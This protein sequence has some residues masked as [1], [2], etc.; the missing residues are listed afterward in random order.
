MT[1]KSGGFYRYFIHLLLVDFK[2]RTPKT[3]GR[4]KVRTPLKKRNFFCKSSNVP[5]QTAKSLT[6]EEVSYIS[7][8]PAPQRMAR[9][10]CECLTAT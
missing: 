10:A 5:R 3:K 7:F 8:V 1:G 9:R 6:S 2:C 4:L